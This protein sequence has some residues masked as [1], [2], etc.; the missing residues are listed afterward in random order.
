MSEDVTLV[1]VSP[2]PPSVVVCVGIF[3]DGTRADWRDNPEEQTAVQRLAQRYVGHTVYRGGFGTDERG[4]WTRTWETLLGKGRAAKFSDYREILKLAK[5]QN[6]GATVVV[7]LFG[8]SR[9]GDS[10]ID[11]VPEC[12]KLG[13]AVRFL[14]VFDPVP[15]RGLQALVRIVPFAKLRMYYNRPKVGAVRQVLAGENHSRITRHAK[16]KD[17]D[18]ALDVEL[19][20]G[21][22]HRD[23]VNY[24]GRYPL[25][26]KVMETAAAT[27]GVVWRKAA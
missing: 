12:L 21:G 4:W 8:W 2:P 27:A 1:L 20:V 19:Y 22:S 11:F 6:P 10:A 25:A 24:A 7:D 15:A 3:E 17:L 18:P 14:G 5:A 9:G 16:I 26:E 23:A 13:V